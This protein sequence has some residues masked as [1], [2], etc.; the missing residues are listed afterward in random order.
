[1]DESLQRPLFESAFE[2]RNAGFFEVYW[3]DID[4]E[5]SLKWCGGP[6]TPVCCGRAQRGLDCS[7]DK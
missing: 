4:E 7:A 2:A 5:F 3:T 1:M 6:I